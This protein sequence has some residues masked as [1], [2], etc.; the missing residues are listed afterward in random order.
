[1]F[2]NISIDTLSCHSQCGRWLSQGCGSSNPPPVFRGCL[3]KPTPR[4][5]SRWLAEAAS[6][7][8]GLSFGSLSGL[9]SAVHF[10]QIA[11]CLKLI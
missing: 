11:L 6:H 10:G 4:S 7:F 5:P 8:K 2:A 3:A 1:M 9:V